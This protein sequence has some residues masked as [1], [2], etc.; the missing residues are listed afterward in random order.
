MYLLCLQ[1]ETEVLETYDFLAF[2]KQRSFIESVNHSWEPTKKKNKDTPG[3]KMKVHKIISPDNI[4]LKRF[5]Y[6]IVK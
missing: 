2:T 3:I 4:I 6:N 1:S 5:G